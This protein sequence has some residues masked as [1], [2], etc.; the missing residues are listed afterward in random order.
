MN[1]ILFKLI[2]GKG[3]FFL[4]R[5]VPQVPKKDFYGFQGSTYNGPDSIDNFRQELQKCKQEA[6]KNGEIVNPEVIPEDWLNPLLNDG[7][8][9]ILPEGMG[10][11]EFGICEGCNKVGLRH[12]AHADSCGNNRSYVRLLPEKPVQKEEESVM[13]PDDKEWSDGYAKGYFDGHNQAIEDAKLILWDVRHN[14]KVSIAEL[15]DNISNLKK[16]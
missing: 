16:S 11:E 2:E 13:T 1:K 12:C 10:F 7:E 8:T 15:V 3:K 9:F 14:D 6:L 5:N 4:M